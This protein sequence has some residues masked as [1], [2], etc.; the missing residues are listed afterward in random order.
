VFLSFCPPAGG[1]KANTFVLRILNPPTTYLPA[2]FETWKDD[3]GRGIKEMKS[4][5]GDCGQESNIRPN[6][7]MP[8]RIIA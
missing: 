3:E 5:T 4:E 1:S 6:K 2:K 7:K 8:P